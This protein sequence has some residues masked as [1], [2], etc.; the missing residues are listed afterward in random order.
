MPKKQNFKNRLVWFEKGAGIG[1]DQYLEALS[2]HVLPWLEARYG[3]KGDEGGV[4][5][6]WQQDRAPP[7][8]SNKAQKWCDEHFKAFWPKMLW[9]PSSPD[10]NPL[11]FAI[12]GWLEARACS[13]PHTSVDALKAA[14]NTEWANM[15]ADFIKRSCASF[16]PRLEAIVAAQGGHIED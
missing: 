16:R 12:W 7:H 1:T 11:D 15:P 9:P 4:P 10:A 6:C 8:T 5:Y 13:V 14:V 3:A 2:T